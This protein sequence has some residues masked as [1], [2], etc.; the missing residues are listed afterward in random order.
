MTWAAVTALSSTSDKSVPP[1]N[2]Q[3]KLKRLQITAKQYVEIH[4]GDMVGNQAIRSCSLSCMLKQ[5]KLGA[6]TRDYILSGPDEL[7]YA[8]SS[9]LCFLHETIHSF[10]V[11]L[12]RITF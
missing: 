12:A 9:I 1:F 4:V 6:S 8:I 3:A 5:F 11:M 7:R 10:A 2:R